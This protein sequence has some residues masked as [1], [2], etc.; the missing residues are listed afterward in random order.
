MDASERLSGDKTSAPAPP[1]LADRPQSELGANT[2]SRF[3]ENRPR[4]SLRLGGGIRFCDDRLD[5]S[6]ST[7]RGRCGC[8]RGGKR[9]GGNG[10]G[11]V[12]VPPTVV[13][14]TGEEVV[15]LSPGAAVEVG[16]EPFELPQAASGDTARTKARAAERYR[17]CT[18]EVIGS[19]YLCG[20]LMALARPSAPDWARGAP[21]ERIGRLG[22][23]SH[24]MKAMYRP[25]QDGSG[26]VLGRRRIRPARY[27]RA[28]AP[29]R[30]MTALTCTFPSKSGPGR[31]GVDVDQVQRAVCT[32][33]S[34]IG[35]R[36]PQQRASVEG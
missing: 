1:G 21:C 30:G 14:V 12:P 24:G 15:V 33:A 27:L 13:V 34:I 28:E 22:R 16:P 7:A 25:D 2:V 18:P 20:E 5:R 8:S 32:R 3:L 10:P 36:T 35:G 23:V 29:Q 11:G 31:F 17:T 6:D 19:D 26:T 4:G 9:R